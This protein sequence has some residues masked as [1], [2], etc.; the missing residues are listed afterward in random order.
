MRLLEFIDS[1]PRYH[2]LGSFAFIGTILLTTAVPSTLL[3]I[4]PEG[5]TSL[6]WTGWMA[7]AFVST[8]SVRVIINRTLVLG[9]LAM[10]VAFTLSCGWLALVHRL[11]QAGLG[12]PDVPVWA[13]VGAALGG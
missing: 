7:I 9:V 1:P 12:L 13:L 10:G 5:W 6:E 3:G 11:R 2:P 4:R 8:F